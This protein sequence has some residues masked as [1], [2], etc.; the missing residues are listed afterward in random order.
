MK[1]LHIWRSAV[2]GLPLAWA[3]LASASQGAAPAPA[4]AASRLHYQSAFEGYQR[5]QD[6]APA[7]WRGVNDT[8]RKAAERPRLQNGAA[9][10]APTQVPTQAS[11]HH[12]HHG[13]HGQGAGK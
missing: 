1:H 11:P 7:D 6:V 5:W 9:H 13:H 3:A 12:G 4:P 10:E 8:V 2:A